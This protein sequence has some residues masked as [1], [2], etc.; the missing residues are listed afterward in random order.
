MAKTYRCFIFPVGLGKYPKKRDIE[1][2]ANEEKNA[3]KE[4]NR[5]AD[6]HQSAGRWSLIEYGKVGHES[7]I[8]M[9]NGKM[10]KR[11]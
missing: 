4:C 2:K 7:M 1:I 5:Y 9:N 11:R 8:S 10:S 3:V 6:R